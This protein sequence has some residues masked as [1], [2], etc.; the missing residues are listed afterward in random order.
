[1]RLSVI[2]A[3]I[4]IICFFLGGYLHEQV[5]V[6]I[7]KSY[8]IKS[9]VYYFKY[10]VTESEKRCPNDA[11]EISHAVNE[12]VGYNTAQVFIILGFGLLIIICLIE[13]RNDLEGR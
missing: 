13:D 7:F 9:E 5:H 8:G 12:A 11:C 1:M 4:F 10:L 2:F 6:S 3:V